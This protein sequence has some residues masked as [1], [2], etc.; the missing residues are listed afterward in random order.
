MKQKSILMWVLCLL[1]SAQGF[2]QVNTLYFMDRLPQSV[3]VNPAYRHKCRTFVGLPGISNINLTFS[4]NSFTLGNIF[5]AGGPGDST[6]LSL[7]NLREVLH[8]KN[9][10]KT[11]F[12]TDLLA[13]GFQAG[14]SYV[15]IN[16]SNKTDLKFRFPKGIVDAVDGNWDAEA[17]APRN[18][19]LSD[20]MLNAMNYNELGIGVSRPIDDKLTVGARARLLMGTGV[21]RTRKSDLMLNTTFDDYDMPE[22]LNVVADFDILASP[23]PATFY[24]DQETG[25]IDSVEFDDTYFED[26]IVKK[27]GLTS[28]KGLAFDFGATYQY[29]DRIT[30]SASLTDL[31]YIRWKSE[32]KRL[33]SSGTFTWQG[34]DIEPLL[35][36][37]D[38]DFAEELSDSVFN[39]L[40]IKDAS[41]PF[42]TSLT[43][44]LY[45]GGYYALTPGI[46]LGAMLRNDIYGGSLHPSLTTSINLDFMK[47]CMFTLSYSMAYNS[48]NNLGAG[49]A[50]KAGWLQ[51]Y[52]IFDHIPLVY[53]KEDGAIIPTNLRFFNMRFGLNL[54]FGCKEKIQ[55][56]AIEMRDS[57]LDY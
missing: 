46:G 56:P 55:R 44:K 54:L 31:G 11:E 4:N 41:D 3:H 7:D 23:F 51:L 21:V 24:Y 10:I 33:T 34:A 6:L 43:P 2:T 26:D 47:A 49:L 50:Y 16:I 22:A 52:M 53:E 15:S 19:D 37:E 13:L 57:Y 25:F 42:T 8:N 45:L 38:Y 14:R 17:D 12:Q 1:I 18:I 29:T 40:N 5:Q 36:D 48:A 39:S 28:N 9:Y 30:F 20:L 32:A 27:V 35:D